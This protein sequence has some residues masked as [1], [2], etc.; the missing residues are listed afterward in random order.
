MDL[1]VLKFTVPFPLNHIV[2]HFVETHRN[3]LFGYLL[4]QQNNLLTASYRCRAIAQFTN[5]QVRHGFLIVNGVGH[6]WLEGHGELALLFALQK[7][8]EA[9]SDCIQVY[10]G[11]LGSVRES[12]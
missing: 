8:L 3:V 10:T 12:S 4:A 11:W 7:N 9:E 2:E 6:D 1:G 5:D